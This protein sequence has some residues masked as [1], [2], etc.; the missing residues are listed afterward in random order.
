MDNFFPIF[1]RELRG[2]FNSPVAY[3]FIIIFLV[4]T[5]GCTFFLGK[6]YES[7]QADL[8]VFFVWHPWLY[9]FLIPAIG[10]RLWAEERKS[11]TI[12][13]LFTLP[14]NLQEAVVAKFAAAWAFIGVALLLTF[15]MILTVN[16]LGSPDNRVILTSYLGSFLMAGAYLAVACVTSS[17]TKNQVISFVLSVIICFVLVLSGHGVFTEHLNRW[18]SV[19]VAEFISLFSFTTHFNALQRGVIDTRDLVFFL[20][21]IGTLLAA[22]MVILEN[23]KHE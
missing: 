18:L 1:K 6:F 2:Y 13:L 3:V 19:P 7:M 15:P 4:A 22:T 16:H 9:L 8:S 10:M 23:K 14:V 21:V 12:E 5:A 17:L 11:G 20:S